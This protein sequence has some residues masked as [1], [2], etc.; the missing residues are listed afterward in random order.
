MADAA[1]AT[2]PTEDPTAKLLAI[3]EPAIKARA[4][5]A[6]EAA[7]KAANPPN[8][9]D[10]PVNVPDSPGANVNLRRY[11]LPTVGKAMYAAYH[12]DWTNAGFERDL[13]Q[14][15]AKKWDFEPDHSAVGA[16]I[17]PK[18]IGEF[19]ELL[20]DMGETQ[21][22]KGLTMAAPVDKIDLAIKTLE[23]AYPWLPN[24]IS[25]VKDMNESLTVTISG[26]GSGGINVPP[27][28]AQNLFAYALVPR[29]A[30]RR[31]PG[32]RTFQAESN[33]ILFPRESTTA[34]A[35]EASEAATLNSADATLSQQ[36]V[37]V[38]KQY[39]YRRW[40]N[41]LMADATPSFMEFLGNTVARDLGIEQD[42][43]FLSGTGSGAQITGL[44]NFSNTTTGPSL[45]AN[46]GT[47]SFDTFMDAVYNLD[48]ANAKAGAAISH[49]RLL[50]SL[51]KQKDANGRYIASP[52]FGIPVAW[53][54]NT[55]TNTNAAPDGVLAELLPTYVSTNISITQTVGN[56]SDC[57]SIIVFDPTQLVI[58]ERQGIEIAFSPH[59]L[60]T[61]DQTAVRATARAT[62]VA[63][64]PAAIELVTGVRA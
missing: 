31:V 49:P 22:A 5:A 34:G 52:N 59:I 13:Q 39:A 36:T 47:P 54:A 4:E 37:V 25:A 51:R 6:A 29:V 45:G 38:Q 11:A 48:N 44:L 16:L 56:N 7:A 15:A 61:T 2:V 20:V 58:V 10:R 41:E 33:R 64:Q 9:A 28:F 53:G 60:F 8:A 35:S 1:Q 55:Q 63:I 50:N 3:L 57:S 27:Q 62:I 21:A 14:A 17:W 18:D 19:Y 12:N 23:G 26:G 42:K 40:S 46:G 32:V 30:L 43:Q 24:S